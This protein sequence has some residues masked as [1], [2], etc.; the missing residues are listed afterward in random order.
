MITDEERD[1]IIHS[2]GLTPRGRRRRRWSF[3]SHYCAGVGTDQERTV[4][5]MAE[6]G[7]MR[8]GAVINNGTSRFYYVTRGGAEAAGMLKR[9]R[10][11][12]V[13]R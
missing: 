8:A 6:R 2:L 9:C 5:A 13:P 12:D 7:L 10:T 3:R 4:I 1:I 11:E